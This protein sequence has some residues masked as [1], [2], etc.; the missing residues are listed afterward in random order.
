MSHSIRH[1][2]FV[3]AYAYHPVILGPRRRR[4]RC[5]IRR[6]CNIRLLPVFSAHARTDC[7][8]TYDRCRFIFSDFASRLFIGSTGFV[9]VFVF[10]AD[11]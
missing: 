8:Q 10:I 2:I 5:A 4:D 9:T 7:R 3:R 11:E 1:S 6:H